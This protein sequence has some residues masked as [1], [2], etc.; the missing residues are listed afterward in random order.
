MRRIAAR[1]RSRDLAPQHRDAPPTLP[2]L[3]KRTTS[4]RLFLMSQNC[5]SKLVNLE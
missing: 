4:K 1:N 2:F 5:F 3:K